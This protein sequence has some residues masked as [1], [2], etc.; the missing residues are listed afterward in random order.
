ML[1]NEGWFRRDDGVGLT[2]FRPI[3]PY[4]IDLVRYDRPP[5]PRGIEEA[6]YGM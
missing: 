1:A 4:Q 2:R 5:L 6:E 3:V